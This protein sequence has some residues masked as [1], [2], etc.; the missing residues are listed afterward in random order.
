M[1]GKSDLWK[2]GPLASRWLPLPTASNPLRDD[3]CRLVHALASVRPPRRVLDLGCGPGVLAESILQKF[4]D[5]RVV[6]L[7]IS[8]VS[9]AK[10]RRKLSPYGERAEFVECPLDGDWTQ[11]VGDGF[12]LVIAV[13]SL[14]HVP[15]ARKPLVIDRVYEALQ[16]G[17]LFVLSDR[18]ELHEQETFRLYVAVE[19]LAR[20][21]RGFPSLADDFCRRAYRALHGSRGDRP[22]SVERHLEWMRGSGFRAEC[23]WRYGVRAILVGLRSAYQRHV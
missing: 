10:A 20:T 14:H 2:Q 13:Q 8:P 5:A 17:G 3:Q 12:D 6:C 15:R 22:D 18:I 19:N 16:P 1:T 7:D 21:A 4:A 11:D 9:L 23:L